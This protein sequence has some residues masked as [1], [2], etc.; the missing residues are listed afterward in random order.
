M[1]FIL[2]TS[3][4]AK[5]KEPDTAPR[6]ECHPPDR[7]TCQPTYLTNPQKCAYMIGAGE[8][9]DEQRGQPLDGDGIEGP[10]HRSRKKHASAP[11]RHLRLA[12]RTPSG[13]MPVRDTTR[14]KARV[15][16]VQATT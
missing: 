8:W 3:Q 4:T 9:R 7:I 15:R 6:P 10:A 11:T 2:K 12:T 16:S 5:R 13:I 1:A 14:P